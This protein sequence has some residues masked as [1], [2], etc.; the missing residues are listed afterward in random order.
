MIRKIPISVA[1]AGFCAL[2]AFLVLLHDIFLPPAAPVPAPPAPPMAIAVDTSAL[3]ATTTHLDIYTTIDS[4]PVFASSRRPSQSAAPA[5]S[6]PPPVTFS[7]VGIINAPDQTFALV[8]DAGNTSAI[9]LWEG[10]VIDGWTVARINESSILVQSGKTF[11]T[12]KIVQ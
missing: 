4:R 5:A 6:G 10:S 12:I 2:L 7:L 1:T 3:P 9:K 11:E 8:L